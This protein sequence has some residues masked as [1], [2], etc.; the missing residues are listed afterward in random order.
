MVCC[1]QSIDL[2]RAARLHEFFCYSAYGCQENMNIPL[3]SNSTSVQAAYRTL[4][5]KKLGTLLQILPGSPAKKL[6][7]QSPICKAKGVIVRGGK[8][9]DFSKMFMLVNEATLQTFEMVILS[10]TLQLYS[11]TALG[12]LLCTSDSSVWN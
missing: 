1:Q 3:P 10:N 9:M 12:V 4:A 6:A 7:K 2:F 11:W 5:E 8:I